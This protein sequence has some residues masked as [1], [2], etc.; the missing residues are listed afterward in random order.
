MFQI[1]VEDRI[2]SSLYP[3]FDLVADKIHEIHQNGGKILVYCRAGQSRSAALCMAYFI[4]YH[5]LSFDDAFQFVKDRRP[6]IHPNIGFVRQLKEFREKC[7]KA[8]LLPPPPL[9]PVITPPQLINAKGKVVVESNDNNNNITAKVNGVS[10][11]AEPIKPC[12]TTEEQLDVQVNNLLK[13]TKDN[14]RIR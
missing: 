8:E 11:K 9:S 4:K 7:K 3:Y 14:F 5:K 2:A 12:F 10:K 6:I 1:A 13:D